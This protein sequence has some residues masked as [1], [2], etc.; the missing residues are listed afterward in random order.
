MVK[1]GLVGG[2]AV[3]GLDF[4]LGESVKQPHTFV[5]KGEA[6]Q[7]ER[8]DAQQQ[9]KTFNH[10][11]SERETRV[12]YCPVWGTPDETSKPLTIT[13]EEAGNKQAVGQASIQ[14]TA[15]TL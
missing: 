4:V 6:A 10:D 1:P 7:A 2:K 13:P 11:D 14:P 15:V 12:R 8:E 5:G 3:L 9:N